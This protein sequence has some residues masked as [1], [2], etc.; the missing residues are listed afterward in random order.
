MLFYHLVLRDCFFLLRG[1]SAMPVMSLVH[2]FFATH[3]IYSCSVISACHTQLLDRSRGL[4]E[5]EYMC[6]NGIELMMV[7]PVTSMVFFF[8][9]V[10]SINALTPRCPYWLYCHLKMMKH[11]NLTATFFF[12]SASSWLLSSK[13]R[14][15]RPRNTV[16]LHVTHFDPLII[17]E[18]FFF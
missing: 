9:F 2:A 10:F 6:G 16:V 15:Y 13:S 14:L 5:T 12:Q 3:H 11:D 18:H 1:R 7:N 17:L 8:F 4:A